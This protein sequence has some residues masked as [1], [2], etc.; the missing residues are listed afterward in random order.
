[1]SSRVL[2]LHGLGNWRPHGHWQRWL[3]EQLHVCGACVRY[4]QLPDPDRPDL[5]AWLEAFAA[6][7]G[8]LGGGQRI[9][10]C[11]SLACALWYRASERGLVH[12]RADR[13]LLVAP[14]GRSVLAR[15]VTAA[16]AP[17]RWD[18]D[19]LHASAR[20]TQLIA[21]DDD[22][23]CPEGPAAQV[24]GDTL[25]LRSSTVPGAGHL[26]PAD[27]YGP[28]PELLAWCLY[29]SAVGQFDPGRPTRPLRA[30]RRD[31][32]RARLA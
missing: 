25:G 32:D 14:P 13:V 19:V 24:Y 26:T 15:A 12:P 28:W 3:V 10:V 20:A 9:V 1:V 16:F 29:E 7:Y 31:A 6:E 17:D 2:V 30:A 23:H 5:T 27:G 21:S 18:A 11:H 8:K 4:P 22:P